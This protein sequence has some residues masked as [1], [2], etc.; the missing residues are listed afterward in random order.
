MLV[1]DAC[2]ESARSGRPVRVEL[3]EMPP[4]YART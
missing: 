1:A 2:S 3:P 4:I